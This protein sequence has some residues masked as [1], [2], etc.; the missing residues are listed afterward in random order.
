MDGCWSICVVDAKI[1]AIIVSSYYVKQRTRVST[2][3]SSNLLILDALFAFEFF[4]YMV[5]SS[6]SR[7]RPGGYALDVVPGPVF[8]PH[9][10]VA[11]N[12][13]Q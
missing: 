12:A 9:V 11:E 1:V 3:F 5:Y 6:T 7:V 13:L 2:G 8:W 4:V 10:C